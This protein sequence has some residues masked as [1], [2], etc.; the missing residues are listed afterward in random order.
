MVF[1]RFCVFGSCLACLLFLGVSVCCFQRCSA[2]RTNSFGGF[3]QSVAVKIVSS[4]AF[5]FCN[6]VQLFPSSSPQQFRNVLHLFIGDIFVCRQARN[7]RFI[8]VMFF[9][10]WDRT[11][12][13]DPFEFLFEHSQILTFTG[14]C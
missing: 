9:T 3:G 13:A 8:L 11:D 12:I 14:V 10:Y 5:R 2:D 4:E 6:F 7:T 1:F